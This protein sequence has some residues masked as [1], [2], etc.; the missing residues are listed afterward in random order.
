M[1]VTWSQVIL[2]FRC[3]VPTGLMSMSSSF[4]QIDSIYFDVTLANKIKF[5][6][7]LFVSQQLISYSLDSESKFEPSVAITTAKTTT[8]T[9]KQTKYNS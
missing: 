1:K 5:S 3:L 7:H 6:Y 2:S 4:D 8:T 9:N